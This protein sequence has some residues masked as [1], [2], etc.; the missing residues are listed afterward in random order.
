MMTL[1]GHRAAVERPFFWG[2]YHR[3][4]GHL[5]QSFIVVAALVRK[6]WSLCCVSGTNHQILWHWLICFLNNHVLQEQSWTAE[7]VLQKPSC[8]PLYLLH[9]VYSLSLSLPKGENHLPSPHLANFGMVRASR[10]LWWPPLSSPWL[11][12]MCLPQPLVFCIAVVS[13]VPF[14]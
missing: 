11:C 9:W 3:F 7:V 10:M 1:C 12:A 2:V 13:W 6:N 8:S 4:L 14:P 5:K